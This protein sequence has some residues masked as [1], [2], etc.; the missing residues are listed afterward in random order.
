MTFLSSAQEPTVL[1]VEDLEDG[2]NPS[3]ELDEL[4]PFTRYDVRVEAIS[5]NSNNHV[6]TVSDNFFVT[7]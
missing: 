2:E 7:G 5:E 3:L 1:D 6:T 4:Q